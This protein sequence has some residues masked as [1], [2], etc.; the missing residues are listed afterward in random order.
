[1]V[2]AGRHETR[3]A[4]MKSLNVDARFCIRDVGVAVLGEIDEIHTLDLG[5]HRKRIRG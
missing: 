2:P 4:R 3:Y 5:K 1:M